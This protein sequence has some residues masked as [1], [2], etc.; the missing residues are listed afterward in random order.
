MT[1][2]EQ[3]S[4]YAFNATKTKISSPSSSSSLIKQTNTTGPL[5]ITKNDNVTTTTPPLKLKPPQDDSIMA[6]TPPPKSSSDNGQPEVT[7]IETDE[8]HDE[9]EIVDE[10]EKALIVRDSKV[11]SLR[12]PVIS[13]VDLSRALNSIWS[14]LLV[15]KK[16]LFRTKFYLL[17]GSEAFALNN[18]NLLNKRANPN[19]QINQ[20]I[21]VDS[22]KIEDLEK[23][24]LSSS[25]LL[26]STS[27]AAALSLPDSYSVLLA[28]PFAETGI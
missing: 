3:H 22:P 16:N 21:R 26:S 28:L 20:R 13:A 25:P 4:A 1:I 10:L 9:G 18:L 27:S 11:A 17:A 23:S 5:R 12:K 2:L 7:T 6:V 15:L 14:G 19:L 24:L 8:D